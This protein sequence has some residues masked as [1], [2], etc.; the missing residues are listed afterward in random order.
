RRGAHSAQREVLEV[1]DEPAQGGI[2]EGQRVSPDGP[3]QA[4]DPEDGHALNDGRD[5]VL[6]TDQ[7][8]V[9]EPQSRGH[10]HHERGSRDDPGNVA[11]VAQS[12]CRGD[13]DYHNP[14]LLCSELCGFYNVRLRRLLEFVRRRRWS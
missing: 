9:E 8:S 7:T 10:D 4:H 2:A 1:S 13:A 14:L 11:G 12:A 3:G 6:T 5:E